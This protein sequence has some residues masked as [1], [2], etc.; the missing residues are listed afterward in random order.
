MPLIKEFKMS[1]NDFYINMIGARQHVYADFV[2]CVNAGSFVIFIA[3][4]SVI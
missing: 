2:T 3:L 1:I 4:A